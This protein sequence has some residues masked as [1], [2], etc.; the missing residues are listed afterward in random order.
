[1][2][3]RIL[4]ERITG[5]RKKKNLGIKDYRRS[6]KLW[7]IAGMDARSTDD[8]DEGCVV[9]NASFWVGGLVK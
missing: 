7:C 9:M 5:E 8:D 1:M 2:I 3:G 6:K 4:R